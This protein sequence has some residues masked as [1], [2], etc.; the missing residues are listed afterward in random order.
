MCT[1]VSV[2]RPPDSRAERPTCEKTSVRS[3]RF[4]MSSPSITSAGGRVPRDTGVMCTSQ[5]LLS[6]AHDDPLYLL[7]HAYD[8]VRCGAPTVIQEAPSEYQMMISSAKPY[9][10]R[11]TTLSTHHQLIPMSMSYHSY[12]VG[13]RGGVMPYKPVFLTAGTLY[14]PLAPRSARHCVSRQYLA[15]QAWEHG[16]ASQTTTAL[17]VRPSGAGGT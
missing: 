16:R 15:S 17:V 12:A 2:H 1:L 3:I 11:L 14:N 4:T 6:K 13:G 7:N 10:Q 9:N 5:G 8:G